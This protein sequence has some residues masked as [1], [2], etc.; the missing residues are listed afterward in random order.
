VSL[1]P[2][3]FSLRFRQVRAEQPKLDELYKNFGPPPLELINGSA[4]SGGVVSSIFGA[5]RALSNPAMR[6]E[7]QHALS[8]EQ[9]HSFFGDGFLHLAGAVPLPLINA[10]LQHINS[11]IGRGAIDRSI[12]ILVGLPQ[13]EANAPA[14]MNLFNG[15]GSR[16]P[17]VTQCLLGR[18]KVRPP[19]APQV[20]MKFPQPAMPG[21]SSGGGGAAAA[22]SRAGGRG[23][24]VDGFGDGTH[25]P[26]TLLLGVCLSDTPTVGCGNFAVHP[27]GHWTLQDAVRQ[28]V[29]EGAATFSAAGL[30]DDARKPDLG[31]PFALQ[32]RAGDAVLAHQKLPH[33]GM[34]NDSPHVRYQVYFRLQHVQH[35]ALR[36]RWLDDLMLPF[37]G[38]R[39][40]M[41]DQQ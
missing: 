23:W 10:A 33:L 32:M 29:R 41:E 27:G 4:G 37:E 9:L 7:Q 17:T 14:L 28:Q 39:G 11:A 20:A 36:D 34:H 24:H 31:P 15:S 22:V 2:F 1:S 8:N 38:V 12:P 5:A 19:W 25:S 21:H 30:D 40:A 16:L 35:E 13:A 3:L 6:F 18:G 26:F